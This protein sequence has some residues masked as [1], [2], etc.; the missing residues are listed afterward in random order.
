MF[1]D[2]R[3]RKGTAIPGSNVEF[4][5]AKLQVS[6]LAFSGVRLSSLTHLI[7]SIFREAIAKESDLEVLCE[8]LYGMGQCVEELGEEIVTPDDLKVIFTILHEQLNAYDERRAEREKASKEDE[9][10]ED[11]QEQLNEIIEL[12][13]SVLARVA[14]VMHFTFGV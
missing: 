7:C 3:K 11:S 5:I 4:D 10:D 13:T 14:D 9:V 6:Y 1:A 12:E 8:L 2:L